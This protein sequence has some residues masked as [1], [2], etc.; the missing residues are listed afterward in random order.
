MTKR[1]I[2][3]KRRRGGEKR[4]RGEKRMGTGMGAGNRADKKK[5]EDKV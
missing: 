3:K 2:E 4:K 1:R 5:R